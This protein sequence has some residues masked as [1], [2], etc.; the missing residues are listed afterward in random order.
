MCFAW[1][2]LAFHSPSSQPGNNAPL[3][4]QHHNH[5]WNGHDDS[6]SRDLTKGN[7]VLSVKEWN[8]H[9]HRLCMVVLRQG[10]TEKEVVPD[11]DERKNRGGKDS[12][13]SQWQDYAPQRPKSSSPVNQCSFFKVRGQITEKRSQEVNRDGQGNDQVGDD[14]C[15]RRVIETTTIPTTAQMIKSMTA[16]ATPGAKSSVVP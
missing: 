12:W 5:Q 6:G 1:M 3:Q 11:R 8:G 9:R 14:Q 15:L 4:E 10:Q 7:L 16:A 2:Y 13:C